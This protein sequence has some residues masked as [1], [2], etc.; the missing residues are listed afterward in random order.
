MAH[1]PLTDALALA[2]ASGIVSGALTA[3]GGWA[4]RFHPRA[5]LKV[6]AVLQGSCRM[7]VDDATDPIDLTAGDVAVLNGR[8]SELLATDLSAEPVDGTALFAA[9]AGR[10]VTL[11]FAGDDAPRTVLVGG[12]VRMNQIGDDLLLATLPPVSVIP[13]GAP[14]IGWLL[15]RVV[16]ELTTARPGAE[17]ALRQYA[18]LLFLEVMRSLLDSPTDLPP[19]WLRL[20]TDQRLAPAVRSMHAD[21][22]RAWHLND[23]ARSATMSR[24]A[25]AARFTAVAG[26]PPLTYLQHW[27]IRVAQQSLRETDTSVA[28][29][30]A[31]LGYTS[32]SAFSTAFKRRTG[33]APRNY[34]KGQQT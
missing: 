30:A 10:L 4:V 7:L 5:R 9:S 16:Q 3:T 1:D 29:L 27:R 20:L 26:V 21:P 13:G 2:G 32:E 33:T 23:L 17:L 24:T 15:D 22:A 11:P 18:Q 19:G 34:R 14:T 6:T 28:A 25:F 12:H 31:S 8:G